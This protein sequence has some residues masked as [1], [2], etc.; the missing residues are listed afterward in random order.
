LSLVVVRV[1]LPKPNGRGGSETCHGTQIT[2]TQYTHSNKKE[3]RWNHVAASSSSSTRVP[4]A[5]TGAAAPPKSESRCLFLQDTRAGATVLLSLYVYTPLL[6]P[7]CW[8]L[9][10]APVTLQSCSLALA[11]RAPSLCLPRPAA[12]P[13]SQ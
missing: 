12:P 11:V 3:E 8:L 10:P 5:P 6:L 1:V 9:A 7:V 2:A 4:R 13:S